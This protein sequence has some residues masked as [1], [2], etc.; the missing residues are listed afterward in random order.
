MF[1]SDT[2]L[3]SFGIFRTKRMTP[4]KFFYCENFEK[5]LDGDE[6]SKAID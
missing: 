6:I 4:K 5:Y 1:Y 3:L 2:V